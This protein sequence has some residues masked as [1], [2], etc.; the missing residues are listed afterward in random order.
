MIKVTFRSRDGIYWAVCGG[1]S[2]VPEGE[3]LLDS[4]QEDSSGR[5]PHAW[6]KVPEGWSIVFVE[7]A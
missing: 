3:F 2:Q 4:L 7:E 1:V 5:G 6:A